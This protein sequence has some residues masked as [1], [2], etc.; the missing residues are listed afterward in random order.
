MCGVIIN[1]SL[2][3]LHFVY[4]EA[5]PVKGLSRPGHTILDWFSNHQLLKRM[6]RTGY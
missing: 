5:Q 3:V 4:K 6:Y 1:Q 2:E